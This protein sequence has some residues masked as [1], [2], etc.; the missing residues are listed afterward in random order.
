M[1]ILRL[2]WASLCNRRVAALLMLL[3]IALSVTLL[4][5]V[6]KLRRDTRDGFANTLSGTDLIVGARGG[7]VQ[8]LLHAIFGIGNASNNI[9]WQSYQEIA[10]RPEVAWTV[11][12]SLGDS[13][14][15]FRVL[16]STSAYFEHYRYARRMPLA[17]SAGRPFEE[18][19]DTVIG[20]EV[21]RK[22]GYGLGQE[23]VL[24]HGMGALTL[25]EHRDKPFRVVGILA[26]T[27]TPVDRTVHVSL[28]AIEAIHIDWQDGARRPGFEVGAAQAARRTLQPKSI[29]AF[30]VGLERKTQ[31][32]AVQRSIATMREEPLQA[33]IPGVALQELWDLIR[34]AENALRVV[35]F[36]V[37]A[38]S[39]LGMLTAILATLEA[40]RREMAVLRAVGARM[41]HL[42][43]LFMVE[44]LAL[45]VAG[46]VAGVGI[47][48]GMV[49]L[50]R[51]WVATEFGI[52]LTGELLQA[53]DLRL[54]GLVLVAA[55]IVS[56]VPA[57]RAFRLSL[58][59]GLTIRM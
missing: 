9:S 29:T 15:G 12:I 35:S 1:T 16:G 26:A 56:L 47:L 7:G 17:F 31:L 42:T 53:T 10:A 51:P 28:E 32:F 34:V 18:V 2:A 30:L 6:E 24:A 27:G 52:H 45:A 23:I 11:P 13:H 48:A 43:A 57:W 41:T 3:S 8:L 50:L 38:I 14:R 58:A 33:I 19:Y 40:R 21:A 36:F 44:T 46:A 25:T 37:V 49:A 54:L 5:G 22:L 39:L 59:D 4:L 55:F 20:A